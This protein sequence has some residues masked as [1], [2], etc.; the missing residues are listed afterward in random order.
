[1]A[2]ASGTGAAA[3]GGGATSASASALAS[4]LSAAGCGSADAFT[5]DGDAFTLDGD[6][7]TLDGSGQRD[8][9]SDVCWFASCAVAGWLLSGLAAFAGGAAMGCAG[10][11]A[12]GGSKRVCGKGNSAW[13]SASER[14]AVVSRLDGAGFA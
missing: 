12:G 10:L 7:F 9:I 13:A 11:A 1:S 6:A 5:L 2:A 3:G 4:E 14:C 8:A